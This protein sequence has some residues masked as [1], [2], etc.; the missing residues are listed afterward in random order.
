M[1]EEIKAE[2][3][4]QVETKN[5]NQIQ[6]HKPRRYWIP[7]GIF[8]LVV[9][10]SI[11]AFSYSG[12]TTKPEFSSKIQN[13]LIQEVDVSSYE[14]SFYSFKLDIP[15]D[16][17]VEEGISEE[18]APTFKI[19]SSD[20]EIIIQNFPPSDSRGY[21][22]H[23]K[24]PNENGSKNEKSRIQVGLYAENRSRYQNA[25]GGI[26]DYVSLYSVPNQ[27][28]INF[29]FIID[30]D[31]ESNNAKLFEVL[32]SFAYTNEEKPLDEFVTYV[33]PSGW[34]KQMDGRNHHD[35]PD[36]EINFKTIDL[37]ESL[38]PTILKGA[39]IR[40]TREV[41]NP[42][43]SLEEQII[44]NLPVPLQ[45]DLDSVEMVMLGSNEWIR[46]VSCWEGCIDSYHII[47]DDYV[48]TVSYEYK[49]GENPN[50]LD[51]QSKKYHNDL[52]TFL[53]TFKFK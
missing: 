28:A 35:S 45:D 33:I 26:S 43:L 22:T 27:K 38:I 12:L 13:L 44:N 18:G 1:D 30:G 40:I 9:I 14:N 19:T 34:V 39:R 42:N 31:F 15:S 52:I 10:I 16:W 3:N 51:V 53:K 6:N 32:K 41:K 37:E 4:L 48:W 8:V 2:E 46:K 25:D 36:K 5:A 21:Y 11:G 29:Y 50:E 23:E 20:N 7:I 49:A 17:K 47:K 24:T